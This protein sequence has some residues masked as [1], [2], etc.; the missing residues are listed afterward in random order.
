MENEPPGIVEE[1]GVRYLPSAFKHGYGPTDAE[2][3]LSRPYRGPEP[4]PSKHTRGE[5]AWWGRRSRLRTT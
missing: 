2:P 1:N 4:R 3:V 5:M